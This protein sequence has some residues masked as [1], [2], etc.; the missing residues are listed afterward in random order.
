M[1]AGVLVPAVHRATHRI[2]L[3]LASAGEKG[4]SQGEAHVLARLSESG[5]ATIAAL[6]RDLAHRRSTLTSILDRLADRGFITR[7]VARDDRRSF[8]IA[9]TR[10]GRRVATRLARRI[11]ALER[12][13]TS[14]KASSQDVQACLRV[15]AALQAEAE[16]ATSAGT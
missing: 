7:E 8:V 9:L 3:Y 15:L 1:I 5:A 13:V 6:H 2:G 11:A 16:R 14:T 12:A 4:L 10:D